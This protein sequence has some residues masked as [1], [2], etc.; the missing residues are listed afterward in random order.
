ML[1]DTFKSQKGDV[2]KRYLG[3]LSANISANHLLFPSSYSFF[4][5]AET[6]FLAKSRTLFPNPLTL[7]STR[8]KFRKSTSFTTNEINHNIFLH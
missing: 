6:N 4:S 3:I 8:Q 5:H 1:K 7:D 2:K